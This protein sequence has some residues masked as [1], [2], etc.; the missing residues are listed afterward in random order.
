MHNQDLH[1]NAN[2]MR[3][4]KKVGQQSYANI[5]IKYSKGPEHY[6]YS[7]KQRRNVE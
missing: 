4:E 7:A 1:F 5:S 3:G 6:E 2:N